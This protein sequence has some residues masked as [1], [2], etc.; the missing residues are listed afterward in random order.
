MGLINFIDGLIK[1]NRYRCSKTHTSFLFFSSLRYYYGIDFSNQITKNIWL[2]NYVDSANQD[3]ILRNNIKVIINCSKDLPFYF[4]QTEIPYRYRI[5]VND[6]RMENS[7]RIM[8]LH[9]PK[10]VEIIKSHIARDENIYIHCHAGMQRSACVVSA[11]LMSEYCKTFPESVEYIKTHR[12]IAFTPFIN[13]KKSL[14]IYEA[15]LNRQKKK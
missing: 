10:I 6:D 8:Y 1:D 15:D 2:G 3:F 14:E 11:Y 13:F 9:L 5:P 12:S 7:L 4:T